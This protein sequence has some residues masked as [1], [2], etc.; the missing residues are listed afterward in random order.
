MNGI[1]DQL[2]ETVIAEDRWIMFAKGLWTTVWLSVVC[3]VIGIVLGIVVASVKVTAVGSRN[4][5]IKI[6]NFICNIYTTV[7]R[8]T[9]LMIQLLILFSIQALTGSYTA[10]IIGFGLNSGAYVSEIFRGGINSVDP[11]QMEAGRSLGLN[12]WQSM[13]Y[14]ILPQAI[15]HALPSLFNEFIV[16]IKETSVA[17]YIAVQEL[18]KVADLIKGRTFKSTSL[19]VAAVLYLLLTMGLNLIQKNLEKRFGR[20]DRN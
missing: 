19:Y 6:L 17:G 12:R 2:Y 11:G 13:R 16:L 1:F 4:P 3:C 15:K 9:P 10:S 20:S 5:V 7:V 18:T 8:G 14:I